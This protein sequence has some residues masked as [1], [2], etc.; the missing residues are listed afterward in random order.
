M[1][2]IIPAAN[3]R[4]A[5]SCDNDQKNLHLLEDL[6][7]DKIGKEI[8]VSFTQTSNNLNSTS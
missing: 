4:T 6:G 3:S 1:I 7:I 8:K 5:L 2:S